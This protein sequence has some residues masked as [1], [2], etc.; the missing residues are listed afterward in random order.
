M[1]FCN[2]SMS[3]GRLNDRDLVAAFK[4]YVTGPDEKITVTEC[5]FCKERR[6]EG[7]DQFVT[8]FSILRR[9]YK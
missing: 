8:I 5:R 4:N 3:Q 9:I 2:H 6:I 7:T 1:Y